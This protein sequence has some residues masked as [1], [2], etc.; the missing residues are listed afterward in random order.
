MKSNMHFTNIA[1]GSRFSAVAVVTTDPQRQQQIDE[2]W[3]LGEKGSGQDAEEIK[4]I[5]LHPS[6]LKDMKCSNDQILL[7]MND[8]QIFALDK[9]K[10][11]EMRP[12]QF[13]S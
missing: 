6:G 12:V 4:Y 8:G 11:F 9:N 3:I 5:V 10:D 13:F 2:L 7:L 1:C